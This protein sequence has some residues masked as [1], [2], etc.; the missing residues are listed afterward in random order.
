MDFIDLKTQDKN[1][2][3]LIRVRNPWGHGEW[4][5]DWSDTPKDNNP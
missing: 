3:N 1:Q 4:I 2:F 5:L